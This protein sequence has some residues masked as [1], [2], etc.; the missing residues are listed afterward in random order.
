[1]TPSSPLLLRATRAAILLAFALIPLG[2]GSDGIDGAPGPAGPAGPPGRTD[3]SLTKFETAPGVDVEITSVTGNAPGSNFEPGDTLTVQFTLLKDDGEAWDIDEMATARILVS[4]PTFNYQRV[5]AEQSDLASASTYL[6]NGLWSYTFATPLPADYLPP[7]NDTPAFGSA[8]GELS[9][10][11]LLDGTYT[12]GMYISWD[13]SVD[14]QSGLHDVALVAI[15][16]RHD[17]AVVQ[18]NSN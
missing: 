1:M 12:V 9:G 2:C 3:T 8:D 17:L 18:T 7:Y 4:G 14:G 5:I 11:P 6:G 15:G 16:L 10:Q 13:Y